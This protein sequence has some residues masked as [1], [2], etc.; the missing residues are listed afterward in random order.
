MKKGAREEGI[1]PGVL[2]FVWPPPEIQLQSWLESTIRQARE[3]GAVPLHPYLGSYAS[4]RG[5]DLSSLRSAVLEEE[6]GA[7]L[8][9][10][11]QTLN[12]PRCQ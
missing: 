11:F 7:C 1:G 3:S 6:N 2:A 4:S 5:E 9:R 10:D 12:S 8:G